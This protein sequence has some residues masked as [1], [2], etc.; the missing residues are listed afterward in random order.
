MGSFYFSKNDR[1]IARGLREDGSAE[2]RYPWKREQEV[3][4]DNAARAGHRA[5]GAL[6]VARGVMSAVG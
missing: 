5:T 4:G 3:E 6:L 2:L 1:A